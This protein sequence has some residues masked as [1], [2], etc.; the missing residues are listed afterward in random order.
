MAM[1]IN[2]IENPTISVPEVPED[3][4]IRL[5][6]FIEVLDLVWGHYI[7]IHAKVN[8]AGVGVGDRYRDR[9][10]IGAGRCRR[11]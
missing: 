3:T 2:K 9:T 1:A 8:G 4:V 6:L 5:K 10:S 11:A 7:V